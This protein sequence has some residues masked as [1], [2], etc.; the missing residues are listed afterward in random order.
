MRTMTIIKF[1]G[2]PEL[3]EEEILEEINR[4]KKIPYTYDLDCPEMS[5]TMLKQLQVAARSRDRFLKTK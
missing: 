5:P 2:L 1:S 4:A 3:T